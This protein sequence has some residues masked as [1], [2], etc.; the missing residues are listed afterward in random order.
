MATNYKCRVASFGDIP[1][2][3]KVQEANFFPIN[4]EIIKIKIIHF[5]FNSF[6]EIKSHLVRI[7]INFISRPNKK[8]NSLSGN[9]CNI[10]S[11]SSIDHVFKCI[12]M[13][14]KKSILEINPKQT[15]QLNLSQLLVSANS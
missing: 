1:S 8:T 7:T 12:N 10:P 4:Y 6:T 5:N 2:T 9:Q 11:I 3:Q 13:D 14:F 15:N